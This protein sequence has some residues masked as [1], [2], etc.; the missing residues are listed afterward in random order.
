MLLKESDTGL[1]ELPGGRVETN[2]VL[3]PHWEILGR[4]LREELGTDLRVE[5]GPPI[6]TW[7]RSAAGQCAF[8]VGFLCPYRG[9]SIRL[10]PE[11]VEARWLAQ[12]DASSIPL[13]PGYDECLRQFWAGAG[14]LAR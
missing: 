6:V 4:E 9:G 1:W 12:A 13:A 11:H 8:L 2:E 5:V 10:S 14:R 3:Q 7:T